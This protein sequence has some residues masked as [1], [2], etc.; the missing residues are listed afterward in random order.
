[1][2]SKIILITGNL[3]YVGVE[4]VKFLKKKNKKLFIIGYDV[5][6]YSKNFFQKI[7]N[8]K[9]VDYQIKSDVR[10]QKFENLKKFKIDTVIHL[11][12][13]SNDP[14]GSFF[15]RPTREINTIYSKKLIDWSKNHGVKKFIFASSCS[16]Y[17]FS[18]KNCS[19]ESR[20]NPLTEYA[21]SKLKIEKY[22]KK[23]FSSKFKAIILRFSTACGAS[24]MLRLDLVLNDFVAS[25]IAS[26][27]IKIL[28][29][30]KALRPLID[31]LDMAKAFCWAD[32]YNSKNFLC[33]NVG[34]EKMNY[35]IVDLAYLVK[36][37]L[38]NSKILINS[39]NIDNRSYRVN[40]SKFK[41]FFSGYKNM[42]GAKYSIA[43]L[44][45]MLKKRNFKNKDFRSSN[46]MR[47][48]SLKNQ[49]AK[50]KLNNNL[51]VLHD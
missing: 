51:K 5:G 18:N 13:V 9:Y 36:K 17:G 4:L 7:D 8:K 14:M 24:S 12:A 31:V 16:V 27:K 38:P 23:K 21:K 32:E 49:I 33:I 28:S 46:F 10:D 26:K 11:A 48:I 25:A 41:S 3:G 20:T 43:K 50:K 2:K 39:K 22:L 15:I 19:E 34:N 42:K 35:R 30:G 6:F 1:M 37:F 47:L 29:D 45:Y 40:F 44:I